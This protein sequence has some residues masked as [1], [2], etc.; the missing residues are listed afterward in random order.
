M[1]DSRASEQGSTE[2]VTS[3]NDTLSDIKA[4]QLDLIGLQI[5]LKPEMNWHSSQK[6]VSQAQKGTHSEMYEA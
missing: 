3:G 2:F 4:F 1:Q 6:S 5:H